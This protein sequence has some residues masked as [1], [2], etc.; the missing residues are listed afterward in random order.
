L[1]FGW[2]RETELK[3]NKLQ[4][5]K[6]SQ[7][8]HIIYGFLEIGSIYLDSQLPERIKYHP[9]S[10]Y[11][12]RKNNCIYESSDKLSFNKEIPGY[13]TFKYHENLVLTKEGENKSHWNLPD[14]FKDVNIRYHAKIRRYLDNPSILKEL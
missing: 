14:F 2:F 13:G 7:D 12:N 8:L 6:R 3:N 1:F 11:F 10:D 9:H 4:Y 5:K